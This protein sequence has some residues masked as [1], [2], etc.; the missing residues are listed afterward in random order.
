MSGAIDP[1][2]RPEG[3]PRVPYD[4]MLICLVAV[5]FAVLIGVSAGLVWLRVFGP[6]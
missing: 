3:G 5:C 1:E 2:R 6:A 4:L